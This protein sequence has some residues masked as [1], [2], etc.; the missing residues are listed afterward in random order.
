MKMNRKAFSKSNSLED[1]ETRQY[2]KHA[3]PPETF[4]GAD[5]K[6]VNLFGASLVG[7]NFTGARLNECSLRDADLTRANLSKTDLS[8]AYFKSADV[9]EAVFDDADLRRAEFNEAINVTVAQLRSASN[10]EGIAG[11]DPPSPV[12]GRGNVPTISWGRDF[13]YLYKPCSSGHS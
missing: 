4:I 9:K 5:A 11:I 10:L 6:C 13:S 8:V 7:A 1:E 3:P 2:W 12:N